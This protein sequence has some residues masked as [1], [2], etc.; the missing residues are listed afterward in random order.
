MTSPGSDCEMAQSP[1]T[2]VVSTVVTQY[3]GLTG[4]SK[5]HRFIVLSVV[6][7]TRD[8]RFVP[9]KLSSLHGVMLAHYTRA[10]DVLLSNQLESRSS[11][12]EDE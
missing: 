7:A 5:Y 4:L 8:V 6:T 11:V 10:D 3:R 9:N 1:R 2:D 12:F